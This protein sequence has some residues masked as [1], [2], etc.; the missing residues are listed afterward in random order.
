MVRGGTV[1]VWSAPVFEESGSMTGWECLTV[2]P[3]D[4]LLNKFR[5]RQ[6]LRLYIKHYN[7][8]LVAL[9][10]NKIPSIK[11]WKFILNFAIYQLHTIRFTLFY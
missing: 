3:E 10:T 4:K 6:A 5:H 11:K 7:I 9:V 2:K 1:G 8:L